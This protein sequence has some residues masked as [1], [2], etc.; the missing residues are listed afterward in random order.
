MDG[1]AW[2]VFE[3]LKLDNVFSARNLKISNHFFYL[4]IVL[5]LKY[6]ISSETAIFCL[7]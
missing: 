7:F 5:S 1:S 2:V 3:G 6:C 4:L